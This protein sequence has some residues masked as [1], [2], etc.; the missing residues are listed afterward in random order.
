MLIKIDIIKLVTF[1]KKVYKNK[2]GEFPDDR[3]H[4]L[5]TKKNMSSNI[6]PKRVSFIY[7][8]NVENIRELP[9]NQE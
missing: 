3:Y 6:F 1:R 5:I 2:E 8:L 4:P 9:L 7:D